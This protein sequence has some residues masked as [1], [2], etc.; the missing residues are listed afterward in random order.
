MIL[1]GILGMPETLPDV[2]PDKFPCGGC[3]FHGSDKLIHKPV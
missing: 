3:L 2:P 1:V